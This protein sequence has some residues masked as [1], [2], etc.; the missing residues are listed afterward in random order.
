MCKRVILCRRTDRYLR[1]FFF[2]SEEHPNKGVAQTFVGIRQ[3]NSPIT[4]NLPLK[5]RASAD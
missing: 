5:E 4:P 2:Q 3:G 1:T